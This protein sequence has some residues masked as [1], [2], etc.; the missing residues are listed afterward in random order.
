MHTAITAVAE[1]SNEDKFR[2][3]LAG[4]PAKIPVNLAVPRSELWAMSGRALDL[5]T[6]SD[7]TVPFV[8]TELACT[9]P[10]ASVWRS[11]V[12][13]MNSAWVWVL[14]VQYTTSVVPTGTLAE[15]GAHAPDLD[16]LICTFEIPNVISPSTVCVR[17]VGVLT[18]LYSWWLLFL[19]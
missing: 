16:D 6:S 14:R 10:D 7:G 2:R 5:P 13:G 18:F 15:S 4:M 1:E 12:N 11:G 19:S 3:T 17:L 8:Y 9:F